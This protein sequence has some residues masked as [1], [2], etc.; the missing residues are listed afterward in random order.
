MGNFHQPRA[1]LVAVGVLGALAWLLGPSWLGIVLGQVPDDLRPQAASI[2]LDGLLVAYSLAMVASIG[3]IGAVIL[4]RLTART[5]TPARRRRQARWLAIGVTILVSLLLLDAGA[6]AWSHWLHRH[7]RLPDAGSP[8]NQDE[9]KF[10]GRSF[11][12]VIPDL[13]SRFSTAAAGPGSSA[14]RILVVGESSA[15]GEPYHPWLSV[16]QL[17]AWKLESV[18]RGRSIGLETWATG[19]ANLAQMHHRLAGLTNRP[20]IMILYVGHNE[21]QSRY[22]WMRDPGFY[23]RDERPALYS[24]ESMTSMLLYSPLCRLVLET[25]EQQRVS[26]RPPGRV[27]RELVDRPL[28]TVAEFDE[29]VADFRIRL[30][31]IAGYCESIGTLP[32]FIIP[33]SNDGGFDPSR[34]VLA[35]ETPRAERVA[36]ARSVARARVLEKRDPAEA[37]R[38]DRELVAS[39]PEFAETHYRL[40]RLLEHTGDWEDARRHFL[41]ARERD[42]MP[43]RCPEAFRQAYRDV[44]ARHP[45][46]LLVDGPRVLEAVSPHGILDDGLFHDA[47]HPNIRGYVA[48]AQDL[49]DQLRRRRAFG[50]PGDVEAP[51]LDAEVC[52]RHFGLDASRWATICRREFAFYQVTA[53]IRYDPKFRNERAAAYRR[54]AAAIE[55]GRPPVDAGIPSGVLPPRPAKT[56][57]V[58]PPPSAETPS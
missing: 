20:D 10:A 57:R 1:S 50:W 27:T 6:S 36:F 46:V 49:L 28:C 45:G 44:A 18:L 29:L 26:Q 11:D 22:A 35:P 14:L 53:Y 21:F 24:P 3:V 9:S 58:I 13:P 15:R 39:H 56:P 8:S 19:G 30:D 41:E 25:R 37:I 7:P 34:S 23:Y 12:G 52:A 17:V 42:S 38:M 5:E 48:L 31:A 55:A 33:G 51:L 54:A 2:Y 47:Q 40:A 43:L 16:G 32:V 4:L